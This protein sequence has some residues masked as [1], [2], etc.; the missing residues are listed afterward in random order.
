VPRLI[1]TVRLH[2]TELPSDNSVAV[3]QAILGYPSTLNPPQEH[4]APLTSGWQGESTLGGLSTWF[5]LNTVRGSCTR[6]RSMG[7][8]NALAIVGGLIADASAMLA[9]WIPGVDIA[10]ITCKVQTE[11]FK[12]IVDTAGPARLAQSQGSYSSCA[13]TT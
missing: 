12:S 6:R 1:A 10:C 2:L 9:R 11:A 4:V 5:M 8:A 7:V 13:S 3:F